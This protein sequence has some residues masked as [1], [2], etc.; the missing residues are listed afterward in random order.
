[1]NYSSLHVYTFFCH[2]RSPMCEAALPSSGS[3]SFAWASLALGRLM[4]GP[5]GCTGGDSAACY[6]PQ[7]QAITFALHSK[8]R[9]HF[10]VAAQRVELEAKLLHE[11]AQGAVRG[12]PHAVPVLLQLQAHGHEGLQCMPDLLSG[13]CWMFG[14]ISTDRTGWVS[15]GLALHAWPHTWTSP[16]VP[17]ACRTWHRDSQLVRVIMDGA[18]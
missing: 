18:T 5:C 12:H 11:A 2:T 4:Y 17:T 3:L 13:C 8:L 9:E 6:V 7:A 15:E 14:C 1:M 10:R 16:S